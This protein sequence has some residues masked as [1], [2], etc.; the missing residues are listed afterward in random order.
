[1]QEYLRS[2]GLRRRPR[3]HQRAGLVLCAGPAAGDRDRCARTAACAAANSGPRQHI[4]AVRRDL[5]DDGDLPHAARGGAHRAAYPQRHRS[6][7]RSTAPRPTGACRRAT[8]RRPR[9]SATTPRRAVARP[10]LG[11]PRADGD[12]P[13]LLERLWRLRREGR[14]YVVRLAGDDATPQPWINVIANA[15]FGFHVSAEGAAFT[16]SRNSRDFQLTPWSNDPVINRPGE[17]I[18]ICRPRQPARRSRR[19]PPCVRDPA[20]DLRGAAR[21]GRLD[22][23]RASAAAVASS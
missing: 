17:A 20:A 2:R 19:S 14:D 9:A 12:G 18:Y 8:Q 11:R 23:H 6:S 3:H 1:M 13:R 21:P 4:F 5:M 7:T 15:S 22:L 16:W 10:T